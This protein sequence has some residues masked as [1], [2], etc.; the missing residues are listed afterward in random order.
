MR[1]FITTTAAALAI[2]GAASAQVAPAA[3]PAAR[4]TSGQYI[5]VSGGFVGSSDYDYKVI[6]GYKLEADVDSGF[7]G[8]VAWGQQLSDTWR[9]ELGAGYR[10]Q[11]V[12]SQIA[13]FAVSDDGKVSAI[14]LDINAY[15]DFPIKGPFKPYVGAGFGVAGVKFDDGLLDDKGS[16]LALRAMAGASYQVSPT[17]AVFAEGRYERIGSLKVKVEYLGSSTKSTI[18][19]SSFGALAGVRFGF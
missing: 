3:K 11:D 6:P 19:M 2:A 12:S 13:G 4:P 14:S 1:L 18:D 8:S 9:V 16:G 17:L 15:Y 7:Q 10:K 5:A